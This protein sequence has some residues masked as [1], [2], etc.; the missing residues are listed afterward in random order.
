MHQEL[1]LTALIEPCIA[2]RVI[3]SFKG[4]VF[5]PDCQ[6]IDLIYKTILFFVMHFCVVNRDNQIKKQ[7]SW[8]YRI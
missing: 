7:K 4:P 5:E 8:A 6:M 1:G 2:T 3:L